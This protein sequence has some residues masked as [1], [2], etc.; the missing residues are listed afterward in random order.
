MDP[1]DP[2]SDRTD[3]KLNYARVHLE[4][5]RDHN[6]RGTGDDFERAHQESFL[7][8]LLGAIDA[9]LQELNVYYECGLSA[10]RVRGKTLRREL[11]K[12]GVTSPELEKL[13]GLASNSKSWLSVAKELRDHA[14]HRK[15]VTRKFFVGGERDGEIEFE[16]PRTRDP[17]RGDIFDAF[18]LWQQE[19]ETLL[20]GLRD[21]I[22]K[23]ARERE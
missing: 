11:E 23:H 4:E 3:A 19:M 14:T 15:A 17:I 6:R 10:R 13:D 18:E 16:D 21:E 12:R 1:Q 20:S 8:H 5:L 2:A 9:F 22:I 7:Y